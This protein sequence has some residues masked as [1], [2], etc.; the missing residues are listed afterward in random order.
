MSDI[1][2]DNQVLDRRPFVEIM[3]KQAQEVDT[4]DR[5]IYEFSEDKWAIIKETETDRH[6]VQMWAKIGIYQEIL[7]SESKE[8]RFQ[9]EDI[10]VLVSYAKI[11]SKNGKGHTDS[12]MLWNRQEQRQVMVGWKVFEKKTDSERM[13]ED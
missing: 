6:S 3:V 11:S 7:G 1:S 2:D 12:L 5:Y 4:T 9:E 10:K 13:E 8:F